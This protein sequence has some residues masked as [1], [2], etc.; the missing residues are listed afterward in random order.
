MV[1]AN[2]LATLVGREEAATMKQM[3][4]KAQLRQQNQMYAGTGGVS[5]ENRAQGFVPA[6]FDTESRTVAI[7]RFANGNPA[8]IHVL[9]G[10]P[11]EWVVYRD[12][13]GKV[14]TVKTS[15][16]AGFVCRGTFYTRAQAAVL[17]NH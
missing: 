16:I 5:A 3:L 1:L 17:V 13:C 7:S 15:V 12:D 14:R 9:D 11:E 2:L 6:F 8:P 10:L 4:C